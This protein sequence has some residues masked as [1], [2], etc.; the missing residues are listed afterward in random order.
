MLGPHE[1][2]DNLRALKHRIATFKDVWPFL[3]D[4]NC[5]PEKVFF[6]EFLIYFLTHHLYTF[7]RWQ[8]PAFIM[9]GVIVSPI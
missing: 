9:L 5:T 1:C 7:S 6:F 2:D 3:E 8:K 4:C